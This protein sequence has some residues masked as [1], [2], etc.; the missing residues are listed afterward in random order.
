MD[1]IEKEYQT[2]RA[3]KQVQQYIVVLEN[4][5]LSA[6]LQNIPPASVQNRR[7]GKERKRRFHMTSVHVLQNL[8]NTILDLYR[9]QLAKQH[10]LLDH[11]QITRVE[12]E[13]QREIEKKQIQQQR[14]VQQLEVLQA[15]RR[16]HIV[17]INQIIEEQRNEN[18]DAL[19]Y[20]GQ[21]NRDG[22]RE[23]Y[24]AILVVCNCFSKMA[25]FIAT[26][27]KTS[28]E[29]LA[30]LFWDHVW[31]LHRLPESI[32]S[33]R[34]VQ[35]AV[36]MMKE[37]NNLLGIQT[38]L[39]T[40]YYPQTDGQTERINQELEQYLRVFINHRQEQ[41]P[42]WLGMAEF[43]Y[44]NKVHTATKTSPFKANYG[45]DPKMGFKGRRK[46]KYEAAEKFI[47]RIRKIQEKAKA[48]LGKAQEKMKKF[49]NRKRREEE[50]YR[51]EDLV[52]LSTKDLK[53]QMKG[54]RSEKLTERFVGLYK[55][56][57][58]VSS[59]AIELELPKS[60]KIH[61]VVNVSRV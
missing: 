42:D 52:L 48:V 15:K 4:Y 11:L 55:V 39:L 35:F 18:A 5:H 13:K 19:D 31:K 51:V 9:C 54:R 34:G 1:S 46:R 47:E 57:E 20:E 8:D 38:K 37:L 25:H 30:K 3:E 12:A 26:T 43:A 49:T 56:K 50:E 22:N 58:I 60:I 41:W 14:I 28:A 16:V 21:Q 2:R 59:N 27:E 24:N 36:G 17:Q 6:L 32:I 7:R 53:W 45:Q 33:D 23:G 29:G 44:N 40:A 61:P 10:Q